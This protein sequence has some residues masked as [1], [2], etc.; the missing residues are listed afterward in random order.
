LIAFIIATP[1]AW[2][3]MHKWLQHYAYRINIG[4]WFVVLAGSM[5]LLIALATVSHQAIKAALANPVKSLRT[6]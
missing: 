4:W 3:A 1:I 2:V 6:E 5:A